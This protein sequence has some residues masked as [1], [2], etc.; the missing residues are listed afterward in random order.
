MVEVSCGDQEEMLYA[1]FEFLSLRSRQLDGALPESSCNALRGLEERLGRRLDGRGRDWDRT[2]FS[3]PAMIL[4]PDAS[5][6]E[7]RL[8]DIGAQG[9][10]VVSGA[11][12]R[13]GALW[14]LCGVRQG[15]MAFYTRVAWID[16]GRAGLEFIGPAELLPRGP[17]AR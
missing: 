7:T 8:V 10:Q 13:A 2:P 14:L 9:V 12:A 4:L 5:P 16:G 3:R 15:W 6:V 17:T 1:I 11:W